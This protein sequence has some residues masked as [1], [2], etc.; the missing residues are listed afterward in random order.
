VAAFRRSTLEELIEEIS[1]QL[2]KAQAASDPF[3]GMLAY[4]PELL[5]QVME[6]VMKTREGHLLSQR[7]G[8][9]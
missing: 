7:Q 9:A 5:D 6:S 4:K 2:G 3:R 1:S 8:G